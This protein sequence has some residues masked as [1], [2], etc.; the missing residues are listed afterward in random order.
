MAAHEAKKDTDIADSLAV[1]QY[2][3][4]GDSPNVNLIPKKKI[5]YF[6]Q[7]FNRKFFHS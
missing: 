1:E 7:D 5:S 3:L 2:V 6:R 4:K